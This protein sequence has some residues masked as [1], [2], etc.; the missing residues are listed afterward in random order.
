MPDYGPLDDL[1]GIS[2]KA[3]ATE[4]TK[5]KLASKARPLD[6]DK[7]NGFAVPIPNLRIL[8]WRHITCTRCQAEYE[9]PVFANQPILVRKTLPGKNKY[10]LFPESCQEEDISLPLEINVHHETICGCLKCAITLKPAED[11]Q[12]SLPGFAPQRP[13][14]KAITTH[15]PQGE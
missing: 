8:E 13:R 6:R 2:T 1:L 3:Q 4:A 10:E 9:A 14:A 7:H 15:Y 12:L 5:K 11:A